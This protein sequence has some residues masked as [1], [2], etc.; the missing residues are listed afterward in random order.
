MFGNILTIKLQTMNA[1]SNQ[2][3]CVIIATAFHH[4]F[5][6]SSQLPR[7]PMIC[8]LGVPLCVHDQGKT[9]LGEYSSGPDHY[10]RYWHKEGYDPPLGRAENYSSF[11]ISDCHYSNRLL[12][13]PLG[14]RHLSEYKWTQTR[15]RVWGFSNPKPG[16]LKKGTRVCKP[17]QCC[18]HL[19]TY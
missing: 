17:Y 9:V 8:C 5:P 15:T 19:L 3:E 13:R 18:A 2:Q 12:E 10:P 14:C 1:S 7:V 4:Y 6:W 16:I 11:N